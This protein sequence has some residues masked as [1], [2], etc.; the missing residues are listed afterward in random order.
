MKNFLILIVVLL[1]LSFASCT[2]ECCN[3]EC[4][5]EGLSQSDCYIEPPQCDSDSTYSLNNIIYG[6]E[7]T[8]DN[9]VYKTVAIG[10]QIWFAENLNAMHTAENGKSW[11][12]HDDPANCDKYGRLYDWATAMNLP[13]DCNERSCTDDIQPKHRGICPDGFHIP[14]DDDWNTLMKTTGD[15]LTAGKKLRTKSGWADSFNCNY[16][17]DDYG[18]SALRSGYRVP[19]NSSIW[20]GPDYYGSSG[21]WW[22]SSN[23]NFYNASC[24]S[25]FA[26]YESVIRSG[27]DKY[28]G[29]SVRCVQD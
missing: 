28:Y 6:P 3:G 21:S 12:N 29:F 9:K 1:A 19:D 24:W 2:G 22:W 16:G 18:F 17:T 8:H 5:Q 15:S 4:S 27:Y 23:S 25:I 20:G 14:S 7:V 10:E 26:N 11:C 13:S